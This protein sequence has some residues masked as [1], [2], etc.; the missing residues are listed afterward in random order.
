MT[1]CSGLVQRPRAAQMRS[2]DSYSKKASTSVAPYLLTYSRH[3]ELAGD[4]R[5]EQKSWSASS[6]VLGSLSS[7]T[8]NICAMITQALHGTPPFS[9][10]A[11]DQKEEEASPSP[12]SLVPSASWLPHTPT[13]TTA[14]IIKPKP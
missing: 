3:T 5:K 11:G 14:T 6:I 12:P 4:G 13:N 2:A 8:M 7:F 10:R 9:A 1:N